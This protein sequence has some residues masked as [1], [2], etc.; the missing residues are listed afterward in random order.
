MCLWLI[1]RSYNLR[2][3]GTTAE[4]TITE[5]QEDEMAE[6]FVERFARLQAALQRTATAPTTPTAGTHDMM[7]FLKQ[8]LAERRLDA[9]EDEARTA[10]SARPTSAAP[11]R[12]WLVTT[13]I[14]SVFAIATSVALIVV[15]W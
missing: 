14:V 11:S 1:F 4:K 10:T 12:R 6:D 3:F 9:M 7:P 15:L 2:F 5:Q 13:V 8:Q